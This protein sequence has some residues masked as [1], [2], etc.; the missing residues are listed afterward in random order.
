VGI[1]FFTFHFSFFIFHFSLFTFH[2]SFFIFHFSFF[3]FHFSLFTF[4]FSFFTFHFSFFTFHFSLFT[5]SV[6]RPFQ[7]FATFGKVLSNSVHLFYNRL[8]ICFK[9]STFCRE[10][11]IVLAFESSK[12][13][14]S[15]RITRFISSIL[16][17]NCLWQRKK[18]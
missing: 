7:K 8:K 3:I 12:V 5:P 17:I 18:G 4:H 11:G 9:A 1:Q 16:T 13:V 6:Y 10:T 2:F 14:P 15:S